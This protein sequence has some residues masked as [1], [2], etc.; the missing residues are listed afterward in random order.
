MTIT[1]ITEQTITTET[2]LAEL[3]VKILHRLDRQ[4]Q[5]AEM[6]EAENADL[7]KRV[8]KLEQG[9]VQRFDP[10]LSIEEINKD[11][12]RAV[13]AIGKELYANKEP[14]HSSTARKS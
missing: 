13:V 3:L 6:L 7:R 12:A 4:T 1:S 10:L 9:Q 11:H 14:I 2:E 5:K 8:E